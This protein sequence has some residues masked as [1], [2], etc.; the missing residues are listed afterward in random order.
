MNVCHLSGVGGVCGGFDWARKSPTLLG[1]LVGVQVYLHQS[2][3]GCSMAMQAGALPMCVHLDAGGSLAHAG[4]FG[5]HMLGSYNSCICLP[6][7]T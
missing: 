1:V 7:F 5:H 3:Q 2:K 4:L 6:I